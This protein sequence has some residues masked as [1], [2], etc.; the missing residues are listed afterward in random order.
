MAPYESASTRLPTLTVI[1]GPKLNLTCSPGA[2]PSSQPS[3][4]PAGPV[5]SDGAAVTSAFPPPPTAERPG[6]TACS[7]LSPR[8][9]RTDHTAP[10][11]IPQSPTT[12]NTQS[13]S[14]PH[15]R[16]PA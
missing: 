6:I 9:T 12:P 10:P 3:T 15:F 7:L 11:P 14:S 4:L 13:G 5:P 8:I 2:T 1:I 16:S